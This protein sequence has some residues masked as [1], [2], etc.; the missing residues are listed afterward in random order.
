M[1]AE[2]DV[3][4]GAVE[5]L[6]SK[7]L[8]GY[9]ERINK[10]PVPS[11]KEVNDT[12][13][14]TVVLSPFEVI[15]LDSPLLQRLRYVRQLGVA[16]WVYPATTHTR[17]EHS[18]GALHQ[19][20]QVLTA[21][22][23]RTKKQVL[24]QE[25]RN[26]LRLAALCHDIGHGVMSH[27]SENAFKEL[28]YMED[29]VLALEDEFDKEVKPSEAVAFFLVGSPAFVDL[30][31]TTQ[32]RTQHPLP[33]DPCGIVQHAILGRP[34][35][36]RLPLLQE[37]IS[38]PFDVDKLDYMTRDAKMAGVPVVTDIDR[39]VRKIRLAEVPQKDLPKEIASKVPAGQPS[40]FVQGVA[41][42]GARTLDELMLGRA[43]LFDKIYRHQKVRA[44][45][46]MVA[47]LILAMAGMLKN[48]DVPCLPLQ[49][50]DD[51]LIRFDTATLRRIVG[52]DLTAQEEASLAP[53]RDLAGRLRLRDLFVR[54][55]AY[56]HKLPDDPFV[57]DVEQKAA[58][59]ALRRE[60]PKPHVRRETVDE[61]CKHLVR[62][63]TLGVRFAENIPSEHFA[64]YIA[65]D[66]APPP[67]KTTEIA[68]A[69]LVV[70]GDKLL[71]FREDSADASPWSNAYA[72]TRDL[73]YIFSAREL[74]APVYLAAEAYF[75]ERF[76]V[77]TPDAA[78][79]YAKT[80]M[81]EVAK[82]R[83]ELTTK[84][85]YDGHAPELRAAP[86]RFHQA[87]VENRINDVA[88][89]LGR[90]EGS[91]SGVTEV[92]TV[93]ITA[94]R[95]LAWLRQF[96]TDEEIER[97]IDI[98]E[99]I[100]IISRHDVQ[101]TI[102]SFIGRNPGYKS[103]IFSP[104]GGPKDSSSIL[105]YYVDDLK[106]SLP[107]IT[108]ATLQDAL[109][110]EPERP[111]VFLDDFLSSGGQSTSIVKGWLGKADEAALDED[112]GLPLSAPLQ[113]S[114][115]SRPVG[116]AF[117]AGTDAGEAALQQAL[118]D[119]GLVGPIFRHMD[120]KLLPRAFRTAA[121]DDA[122][123]DRV[124][125]IGAQ[126]LRDYAGKP[127]SK[128][129]IDTRALGYGN[130]GYLLLFPYN[131]PTQTL[132]MLWAGGTVDGFSWLPLAPRRPK[133]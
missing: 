94:R 45:E 95:A 71:R 31:T 15:I 32:A 30:V 55:Y 50:D 124:R 116:F 65:L 111:V 119:E 91:S 117:V 22:Q 101:Q 69:Y 127:R 37:L 98:L 47:K 60:T 128:E 62:M 25:E 9:A 68:R 35:F 44:C 110:M 33:D 36:D 66:A 88:T 56:S 57:N 7:L 77:R 20:E 61:I 14:Q 104:L 73:G 92:R 18:I 81:K 42:S 59:E 27:V 115:R 89:Q 133:L 6:A 11:I 21:L 118:T 17:L 2:V 75:R 123:R 109:V 78:L 39:L 112:H 43:L 80:P 131:A 46:A 105:T 19:M 28:E 114:L 84:G 64:S 108:C 72:L 52:R 100:K 54:A 120:A 74:A 82:L 102:S 67:S 107:D 103:A 99:R 23:S 49:L 79:H 97:A 26:V 63:R 58:L 10:Q 106:G 13:W 40:Y 121:G 86:R 93:Q 29:F 125:E 16:H 76:G 53:A 3:F 41:L 12:V 96:R 113:A 4:K 5:T 34:I 126:L 8:A 132:T 129:W 38:G 70:E 90:F 83:A 48:E 122:F 51:E 85:F 24:T 1:L 130:D 87:D